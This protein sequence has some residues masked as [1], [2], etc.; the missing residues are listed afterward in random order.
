M[1]HKASC[2]PRAPVK[3][4]RPHADRGLPSRLSLGLSQASPT[5]RKLPALLTHFN[6]IP[7]SLDQTL[8]EV[9]AATR[10]PRGAGDSSG[11]PA[12]LT[13]LHLLTPPPQRRHRE[14]C[15]PDHYSLPWRVAHSTPGR[16]RPPLCS[17][18]HPQCCVYE[19]GMRKPRPDLKAA[20]ASYICTNYIS[21]FIS[22]RSLS[23]PAECPVDIINISTAFIF[24]T[25]SKTHY[26]ETLFKTRECYDQCPPPPLI[27]P[28]AASFNLA[29]LYCRRVSQ[30][31]R[32][33]GCGES[34]YL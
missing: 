25:F 29:E 15:R 16:Q 20:L 3:A 6:P 5:R 32:A 8:Q 1:S 22:P 7:G 12:R 19:P 26:P 11:P 23:F 13:A 28:A 2:C 21:A 17:T 30:Y 31:T 9:P 24:F 18:L 10:Q 4:S 14:G 33:A 34:I 27:S